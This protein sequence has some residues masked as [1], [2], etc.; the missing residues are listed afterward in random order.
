M[1]IERSF[2]VVDT[3][4]TDIMESLTITYIILSLF[5]LILLIAVG[6]AIISIK[7]SIKDIA[8]AYCAINKEKYKE[9][10]SKDKRPEAKPDDEDAL[11]A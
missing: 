7:N 5:L 9:I 2:M 1:F 8:D 3:F 6:F 4:S 10:K 11:N